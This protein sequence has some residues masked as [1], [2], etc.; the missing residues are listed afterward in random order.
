MCRP[1]VRGCSRILA[2]DFDAEESAVNAVCQQAAGCA[3]TPDVSSAAAGPYEVVDTALTDRWQSRHRASANQRVA[4]YDLS[5]IDF[6]RL[7]AEFEVTVQERGHAE[8]EGKR[9]K[10]GWQ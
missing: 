4:R 8:P 9:S 3:E 10:N 2:V 1:A 7:R 6:S 5:N